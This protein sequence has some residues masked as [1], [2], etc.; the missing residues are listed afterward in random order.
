[1]NSETPQ[2]VGRMHTRLQGRLSGDTIRTERYRKSQ[3]KV[4]RFQ[5]RYLHFF[6]SVL[7]FT[8]VYCKSMYVFTAPKIEHCTVQRYSFVLQTLS[9]LAL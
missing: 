5:M 9:F 2:E 7:F 3:W 1:L 6:L 4:W 8:T